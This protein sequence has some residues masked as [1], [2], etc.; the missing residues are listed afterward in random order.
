MYR[1]GFTKKKKKKK[2]VHLTCLTLGPPKC[3][4]YPLIRTGI[5]LVEKE[6]AYQLNNVLLDIS[7]PEIRH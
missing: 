5:I 3:K 1:R 4:L 7:C 2:K 6:V